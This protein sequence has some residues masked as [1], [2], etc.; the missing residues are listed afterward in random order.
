M[1]NYI[2]Q[3]S[4]IDL[5]YDND[6][7]NNHYYSINILNNLNNKLATF[8]LDII[9]ICD[10]TTNFKNFMNLTIEDKYNILNE[11]I[12]KLVLTN[13]N[14]NTSLNFIMEN[15]ERSICVNNNIM[16][17]RISSM[18]MSCEFNIIITDQLINEFQK[19]KNK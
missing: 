16:T 15:G 10:Y 2:L 8:E 5:E 6:E 9:E 14:V 12:D 1:D 18:S 4:K 19:I 11:F 3:I 7:D 13:T 17:F